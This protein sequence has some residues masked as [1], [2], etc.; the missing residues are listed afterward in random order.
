MA[1]FLE[2]DLKPWAAALAAALFFEAAVPDGITGEQPGD[3]VRGC[4]AAADA[5]L[6]STNVAHWEEAWRR[7]DELAPL[8][9]AVD[10]VLR[11][12]RLPLLE[13]LP[14]TPAE[15]QPAV[16]SSHAANGDLNLSF[17]AAAAC[18]GALHAAH[19]VHSLTV[20]LCPRTDQPF[21]AKRQLAQ[22][23]GAVASMPALRSLQVLFLQ[24]S[25]LIGN[26]Q[27]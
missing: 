22:T 27:L 9:D 20:K 21:A 24:R 13:Q 10:A 18:R 14:H 23:M 3:L 1:H 25:H 8:G 12:W 4:T 2:A 19:A 6:A 15:W 16:I 5:A 17:A 26:T 7:L 11:A